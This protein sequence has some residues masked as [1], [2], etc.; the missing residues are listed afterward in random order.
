[1]HNQNHIGLMVAGASRLCIA[2]CFV[3]GVLFSNAHA[4]KVLP[5]LN[6][7][8]DSQTLR[9]N[10][11]PIQIDLDTVF[12][13]EEIDDN[14]VRF[15]SQFSIGDVP[16]I[17]DL[18]LFTNRTPATRANFLNYVSDGDYDNQIIHR[19]V[20]G[21]V[22]QG[23]G[24][25][26]TGSAI[27]TDAP[28]V[29]E[30]GISNTL[31][32]V[33]MAKLGSD[34]NSATSQWFINL[35]ANSSNL[36]NQ[37]GGFTAFARVLQSTQDDVTV[38]TSTAN[39]PIFN[40]GGAFT[41]IPLFNTYT[42]GNPLTN[43][44]NLFTT[45]TLVPVDPGDAGELTTLTYAISSNSNPGLVAA[46]IDNDSEF[47]LVFT[48]DTL[49]SATITVRATDSV[50]NAVDS[51]FTITVADFFDDWRSANFTGNDITDDLI[52][53]PDVDANK[54]GVTNLEL[55]AHNLPLAG[56]QLSPVVV[57]FVESNDSTVPEFTFPFRNDIAGLS[58]DLE[59]SEDLG[60][61][62][63]WASVPFSEIS[64]LTN[65]NVDTITL[66]INTGSFTP[67]SPGFYRWSVQ[68]DSE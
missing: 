51:T 28:V 24:F 49:G 68:L 43:Q 25:D 59:Y 39:F 4:A 10:S 18:A 17:I 5:V 26:L 19:T 29:N 9:P 22:A 40:L 8:I 31:W 61:T 41:S 35:G 20:P 27:P 55:F 67:S 52:S 44:L 34:P 6:D 50:G 46:T 63:A 23:G 2:T 12:G 38:L 58:Y 21:F 13:T 53:G 56:L 54:D 65:D 30:F 15:T 16:L 57:G 47:N 1:M 7:P 11:T 3:I 66:R 62:D 37:N 36:D 45:A 14:A 48:A 33:A 64:R 32:T 60:V 42:G